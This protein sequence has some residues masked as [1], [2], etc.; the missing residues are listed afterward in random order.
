MEKYSILSAVSSG[1]FQERLC[2]LYM[3]A[4]DFLDLERLENRTLKHCKVFLSDARN[5]YP[6]L[7]ESQLWKD[8]LSGVP[9]SVVEQQPLNCS[10]ISLLIKTSD[11][12]PD[13]SLMPIRLREI[14]CKGVDTYGQ[15]VMLFEKYINKIK[16]QGL[17]IADHCVRT[18]LYVNDIDHNYAD[19]VRARNDVFSRNG[20]TADT[21]FIAS[22]GIGGATWVAGATVAMDFLTC[23]TA[24][25]SSQ[26]HLRALD[27]LND[28][29]EYGVAFE[30]GTRVSCSN[31]QYFLISGTAS[32]DKYGEVIYP[33]NVRKQTGRLLENIGALLADGGATMNDI[34]CFTIYLRDLSDY[35]DVDKFMSQVFPYT[36]RIILQAKVCRP[37]W[38]VEME[39]VAIK[40]INN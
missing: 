30:R 21:H 8:V 37:S 25:D 5:Q 23:P 36:P 9:C 39:C 35:N 4:G 22:T 17:N 14:E 6:Q 20:L 11:H 10:K 15:T 16:E 27:L 29:I 33:N 26:K 38:L 31:S 2:Q 1:T 13:F 18:W 12:E 40:Q 32:I 19:V 34:R 24:T 28:T 7:L 3:K